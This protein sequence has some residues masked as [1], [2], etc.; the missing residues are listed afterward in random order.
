MALFVELLHVRVSSGLLLRTPSTG[1]GRA[2]VVRLGTD[3]P[4]R[5]RARRRRRK[6]VD[7][8]GRGRARA[9]AAHPVEI[10]GRRRAGE[11]QLASAELGYGA[12]CEGDAASAGSRRGNVPRARRWQG[13]RRNAKPLAHV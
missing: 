12:G 3:R 10:H 5:Q 13:Y 8:P 4:A 7:P 11:G 2:G 6:S 1:A 9:H